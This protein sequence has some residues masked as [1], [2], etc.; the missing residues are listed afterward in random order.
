MAEYA[1]R[2]VGKPIGLSEYKVGKELP[3]KLKKA[4]PSIEELE[5]ELSKDMKGSVSDKGKEESIQ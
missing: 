2:D 5:A 3:E 1:V 4:L